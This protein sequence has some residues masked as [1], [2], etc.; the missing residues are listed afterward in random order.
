M[1]V[2]LLF[3]F[4]PAFCMEKCSS[5][6]RPSTINVDT[7]SLAAA[8]PRRLSRADIRGVSG[9]ERIVKVYN[10]SHPNSPTVLICGR[11]ISPQVMPVLEVG[12]GAIFSVEGAIGLMLLTHSDETGQNIT[13][14]GEFPENVNR[15]RL[16]ERGV[17]THS[18]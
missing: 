16:V 13:G 5:K 18:R 6:K 11:V 14:F 1:K 8:V 15:I 2:L 10:E 9:E 3:L 7:E 12:E 4:L 17:I